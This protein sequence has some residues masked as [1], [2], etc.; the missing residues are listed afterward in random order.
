MTQQDW[1]SFFN[2]RAA[3]KIG[4]H[5]GRDREKNMGIWREREK[6]GVELRGGEGG[7]PEAQSGLGQGCP[8]CPKKAARINSERKVFEDSPGGGGRGRRLAAVRGARAV[9]RGPARGGGAGAGV[10]AAAGR[11]VAEARGEEED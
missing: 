3:A 7:R 11:S 6:G 8:G 9:G 2:P 1:N 10:A 4:N 5:K